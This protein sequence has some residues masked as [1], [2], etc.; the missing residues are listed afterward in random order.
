MA[1]PR[2]PIAVGEHVEV[3]VGPIAHGGHCIAHARGRTLLVRH[4]LPGERVLLEITDVA[5]KVCRADA[6]EVLTASPD[7]V[8]PACPHAGAGGC[9]GCDFQHVDLVRQR[10]L[11]TQV[12]RDALR[13]FAGIDSAAVVTGIDAD[14]TGLGWRTR[15][16]WHVDPDGRVGLYAA[17]SHRVIPINHCKISSSPINAWLAQGVRH[18]GAREIVT[19]T[20]HADDLSVVIDGEVA[21][22]RQ[23]VRHDVGDRS[24]RIAASGFW[25][26]HPAAAR[27]LV[28]AVLAAGRPRPGEVWWDLYAGAGLFSA[29]LAEA[30]GTTGRVEA[31][32][33][34]TDAIRDGRRA[35]HDLPNVRLTAAP[36][37]QWLR[38]TDGPVD[39]IVLDPPRTGAGERVVDAITKAQPR[40]IVYVACDPVA[41]AR[42]I[43]CFRDRGY[44]LH[45]VDGFDLFPMTHH[46]EAVALLSGS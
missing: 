29:F 39:G 12:L 20:G 21:E 18:R 17:R 44:E 2:Q 5:S 35:L 13:R 27:T 6:I 36:V 32:E 46:L 31:V 11:K 7:R 23:R 41:L 9:G 38:Q 22:G 42:D 26:V 15:A 30:V 45:G 16:T 33:A 25:Q 8:T 24:W 34:S 10:A 3:E 40:H 28:D 14:E 43:G 19:A 4:A 1:S 37:E